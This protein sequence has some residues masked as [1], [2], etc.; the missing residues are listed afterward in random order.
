[1]NRAGRSG[2]RVERMRP[3]RCREAGATSFFSGVVYTG[4]RT[5]AE[6]AVHRLAF[7]GFAADRQ[8][9]TFCVR[10]Q[11]QHVVR[12]LCWLFLWILKTLA[13]Q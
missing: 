6:A 7:R 8:K 10:I 4:R 11:R 9:L 2:Q 1:M 13:N 3:H 12:P 5:K